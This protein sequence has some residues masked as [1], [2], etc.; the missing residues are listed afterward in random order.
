MIFRAEGDSV[1][2]YYNG[3]TIRLFDLYEPSPPPPQQTILKFSLIVFLKIV[4]DVEIVECAHDGI[5]NR[6]FAGPVF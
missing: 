3:L 1:R 5:E 2:H 4:V 6:A